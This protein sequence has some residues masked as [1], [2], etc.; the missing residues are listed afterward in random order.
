[1]LLQFFNPMYTSCPLN[2]KKLNRQ[3][4]IFVSIFAWFQIC[5]YFCISKC[6]SFDSDKLKQSKFKPSQFVLLCNFLA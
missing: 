5:I 4:N 6:V 2:T 3:L 1:M